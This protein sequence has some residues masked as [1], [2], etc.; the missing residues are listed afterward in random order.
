MGA[1]AA[2]CIIENGT[3]SDAEQITTKNTDGRADGRTLP[4]FSFA[5]IELRDLKYDRYPVY[6]SDREQP[7]GACG[8]PA[9]L[10]TPM[11]VT[12]AVALLFAFPSLLFIREAIWLMAAVSPSP[13]PRFPRPPSL[14]H[15]TPTQSPP[16]PAARATKGSRNWGK[17]SLPPFLASL[18][19]NVR[20]RT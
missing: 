8:N 2:L 15:P 10:P 17:P 5:M 16:S 3:I 14:S 4:V 11:S 19:G 1:A 7:E 20:A 6:N 12:V 9:T 13:F 18:D